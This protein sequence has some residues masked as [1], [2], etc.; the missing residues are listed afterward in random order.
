MDINEIDDQKFGMETNTQAEADFFLNHL[1]PHHIV[2][3]WGA[4]ASTASIAK[5][6]KHVYSIEHHAGFVERI[7]HTMP[8]NSTLYLVPPNEEEGPGEDGDVNQYFNYVKKAVDIEVEF[9]VKFDIILIDG[10][11]RV[12]CAKACYFMG[13]GHKDT[14]IFIHDY[15][16]PDPKYTRKEYF[17]AEKY[18][19]RI[20]GEHT[21][22]KFKIK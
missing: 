2:L 13:L 12:A 20:E 5:R 22:W 10:R 17:E 21:M 14:L 8:E 4:G 6:V 3:E 16:H 15:N 1:K 18:L 7:K 9:G 19:I 11:A